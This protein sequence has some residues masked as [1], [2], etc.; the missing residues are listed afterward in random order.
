MNRLFRRR[1]GLDIGDRI[2]IIDIPSHLKDP[3]YDLKDTERR[4]MRTAELFK[5][6]LGRVFTIYGFDRYGY[7]ELEV[8]KSPAVRKRFGLS[9]IWIE[10]EYVRRVG[11]PRSEGDPKA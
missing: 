3:G 7:I 5:F 10:P 4:E 9:T 8:S 1:L 6:C 2:R 11:K